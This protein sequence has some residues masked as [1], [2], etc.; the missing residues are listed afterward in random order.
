MPF[1]A[2]P[3][4]LGLLT[5]IM[6]LYFF[7]LKIHLPIHLFYVKDAESWIVWSMTHKVGTPYPLT[8]YVTLILNIIALSMI[9]F[10][11]ALPNQMYLYY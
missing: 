4:R 11:V 5:M 10:H 3:N 2:V 7:H 8:D 6:I 1:A 9:M